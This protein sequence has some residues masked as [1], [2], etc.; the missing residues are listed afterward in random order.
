MAYLLCVYAIYVDQ[1]ESCVRSCHREHTETRTKQ[2]MKASFCLRGVRL[3][4][5]CPLL[6]VLRSCHMWLCF[7]L[8]FVGEF[9][10]FSLIIHLLRQC[11]LLLLDR[12]A[13][14]KQRKQSRNKVDAVK[15]QV[16]SLFK[17]KNTSE[18]GCKNS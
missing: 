15:E 7:C 9:G 3:R 14:G 10:L 4:V 1:E 8:C 13:G 16:I 11:F 12:R 2:T 18:Y 5:L 6:C 17:C